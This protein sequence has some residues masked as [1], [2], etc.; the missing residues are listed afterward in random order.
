MHKKE[1][2]MFIIKIGAP[3]GV[4]KDEN[5]EYKKEKGEGKAF[6]KEEYGGYSPK[7]L[8]DKLEDIK[9]SIANQ[10]TK[11]ALMKIDNCIVR[12]NGKERPL[13]DMKDPFIT[14][15]FQLDKMLPQPGKSS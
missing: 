1:G 15:P 12:L 4:P 7:V 9:E 13:A 5:K 3:E 14:S 6:T 8:V 2:G 11:E 10:N